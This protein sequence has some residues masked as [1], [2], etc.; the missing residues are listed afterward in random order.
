M[1]RE[2]WRILILRDIYRFVVLGK[3]DILDLLSTYL[4]EIDR[5]KQTL[6]N[7]G[8][9]CTGMS[10]LETVQKEVPTVH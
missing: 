1:T 6:R 7:K 5:A 8:Y 4:E 10:L 2:G 9:G 3:T